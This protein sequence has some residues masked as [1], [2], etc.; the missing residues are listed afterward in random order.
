MHTPT[1]PTRMTRPIL[2]GLAAAAALI[3]AAPA[4]AQ[5]TA[6]PAPA[7]AQTYVAGS[8][9]LFK[10]SRLIPGERISVEVIGHGPDLIFIPGLASSRET[11]RATAERLKDRYRLHLVQVNGFAGEPSG[12]NASG[13]VLIPV[14]EAIDAYI[15]S[16]HLAPAVVI[17][18]SLG[19]TIGLYLAE[20]HPDHLKKVL[21]VDALPFFGVIIGGP[22][23]TPDSLA[24][25]INAIRSSP[26]QPAASADRQ[27]A[28]MVTGETDRARVI[29]WSHA[30]DPHVVQNAFADDLSLDLRPGLAATQTPITLLYPD[31]ASL[32]LPAG[33]A[34]RLYQGA[35]ASLPNRTLTRID[36]SRHFIMYDQPAVF[37]AALDAFLAR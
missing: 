28:A 32:G 31:N 25:M 21:L 10:D 4:L 11:W 6:P 22:Q 12:A 3:L 26:P 24:P 33:A 16:Q 34:D 20:R 8:T 27:V 23:A 35:F 18:H 19:G 1:E 30:S 13:P 17:G 37:A 29:G 9:R 14:A 2:A 36:A 5:P 7:P 15:A